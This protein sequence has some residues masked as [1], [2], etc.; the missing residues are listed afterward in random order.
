MSFIFGLALGQANAE[1]EC[2]QQI[3]KIIDK[4]YITEVKTEV[5][6][7]TV[8]HVTCDYLVSSGILIFIAFV[9]GCLVGYLQ[10]KR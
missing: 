7:V 3:K 1:A 8:E 10:N 5:K 2:K 6:H 4:G 9:V